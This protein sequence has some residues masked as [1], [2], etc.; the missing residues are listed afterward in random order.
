MTLT[1]DIRVALRSLR[2]SPG[3]TLA[4][5]TTLA[6]GIGANTAI[7]SVIDGVLL[8]PT[9]F[10][11]L[12][13]LAMVWETDRKSGTTR[14]PASVPDFQD[15]QQQS[16]RFSEL[17][18][19]TAQEVSLTPEG[20]EPSRLAALAVS[21]EYLDLTGIHPIIGRGFSPEDDRPG[22]AQVVL[23]GEALWQQL[24]SRDPQ[25]VGRTIRIDDVQQ[26]IIGVVP[27]PADFGTL[28]VLS[29]ADYGK[30]FA[31]RGGQV[32]VDLWMPLRPDPESYPRDTHPIFVMG[33][34]AGAESVGAAQQ[35]MGAI[36]ADLEHKYPVNDAR[37]VFIEPLSRVV[38]GPVRPA[39]FVLMGAVA[40]VLLVACANVASLLLARGAERLREVT[41]RTALGATTRHLVRQFLIES[42]LLT[43]AGALLGLVLAQEG[44]DLLLA[45]APGD[46]PRVGTV[47]IDGRVLAVTLGVT[48]FIAVCFSLFPTF[49]ASRVNLQSALQG[50]A[51]RSAS[52]GRRHRRFRSGLV[53][54][55]LALAV[56]LMTGAGVLIRSLWRLR[57]VDPGFNSAGVLKAEF[58]LPASR[59]PTDYAKWPNW[60][61]THGFNNEL[62]RRVTALPG[63][64]TVTIAGNHPLDAGFT[65]SIRVVGREAEAEDW[66]EPTIRQVD[67]QYLS[68]LRVSLL[69]GR[70]FDQTDGANGTPVVMINESAR[71]RFFG[72]LPPLGQQISFWG[73]KRTIVGVVGN[74]RF[75]GLA[76]DS[77]PSIYLPR[78]QAP[79][80]GGSLLV[81]T[82]SGDPAALA[83]AIRRIV[84]D[85]D[86]SLPLFGVE[87]LSRTLSNSM[88]QRRFT[89]LVLGAF[90]AVALLLAMVGVHGVLSYTVTQRTREIGI[91][92]ALGADRARVRSL[93]LSQGG[94]LVAGGLILGLIGAFAITRLLRA[95]LFGVSPTDPGTFLGVA[96]LLA[97]VALVASYLPAARAARVDPA[98]SLRSE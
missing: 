4:A 24:Y 37:G 67:P 16:R 81:R 58:Q 69:A 3:F 44:L 96:V 5:V 19:F 68:T 22:G 88:G 26:T 1:N 34:L 85:L 15:F 90:A 33:R 93:I 52:A 79:G 29:A 13:R 30:G 47:D 60:P 70:N 40:L 83:P 76:E 41:V 54:S 32:R 45:L 63:V 43:G 51:S 91:R 7:F 65:N 66:P 97:L 35:E 18:A 39:L 80:S 46:I 74:E 56:M 50:E 21:H 20:A 38:F 82:T 11:R 77:P 53:I 86:P 84:A 78:A 71:R 28:Q 12:D 55:E 48:V 36:A 31:A 73:A 42:F 61:A 59:Y 49:Q 94:A 57:E 89:M 75:H 10:P 64:E 27:S 98:V 14:E 25:V 87:P 92:M 72:V 8:R 2:R 62:Q 6:L 9:P 95:L 23:I 17:A